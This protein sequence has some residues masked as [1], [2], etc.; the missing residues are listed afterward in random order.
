MT[1]INQISQEAVTV[2]H[3]KDWCNLVFCGGHETQSH[4]GYSFEI[5]TNC[6]C[7]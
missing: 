5:A 1:G 6:G 3:V 4:S 7:N 2:I